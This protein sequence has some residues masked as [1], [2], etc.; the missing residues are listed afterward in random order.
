MI[1][2]VLI[3]LDGR[4]ATAESYEVARHRSGPAGEVIDLVLAGRLLDRF[5]NRDGR[6]A[7]VTR[8]KVLD[9][10]A[11]FA[12]EHRWLDGA[13]L[14]TGTRDRHD[15]SYETLRDQSESSRR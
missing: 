1:G 8:R 4:A 2:N 12:F 7:I 3:E 13:P 15:L 5:E 6:W 9:W 10:G 14:P 11:S